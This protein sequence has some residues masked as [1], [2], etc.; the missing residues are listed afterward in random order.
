MVLTAEQK[1]RDPLAEN[2]RRFQHEGTHVVRWLT[3]GT[4]P[5]AYATFEQQ[6][7][8]IVTCCPSCGKPPGRFDASYGGAVYKQIAAIAPVS[9]FY[10]RSFLPDFLV[11]RSR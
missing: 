2:A 7:N 6:D 3:G 11:I 5:D 9:V 4:A 8:R 1:V 10:V